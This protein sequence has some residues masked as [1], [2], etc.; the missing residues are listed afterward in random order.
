MG[1]GAMDKITAQLKARL[2][3]IQQT[4]VEDHHG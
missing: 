3:A 1:E 2:P 4:V